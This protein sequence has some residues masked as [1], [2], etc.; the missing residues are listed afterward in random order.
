MAEE[1]TD[2]VRFNLVHLKTRRDHREHEVVFCGSNT[3]F[4]SLYQ[5][6]QPE[7]LRRSS[8]HR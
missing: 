6:Y 1:T 4:C 2:E 3:P 7:R 5:L 8:K